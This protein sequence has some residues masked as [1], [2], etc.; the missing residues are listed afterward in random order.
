MLLTKEC[1]YGVRTI[2][3]LA[4]GNK[5]TVRAICEEELIPPLYG[6]KILK[7]LEQTGL[8]QS[9]QGRNGG[10]QLAKPLD[11]ITLLDIVTSIDDGLFINECLASDKHC[12]INDPQNPCSVHIELDRMQG[13]LVSE[14]QSKSMREVLHFDD[15]L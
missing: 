11:S 4:D 12:P 14:L 8:L 7:K 6:Y 15:R 10:Y 13:L 2:R 9:I 3:A 1:D 5:K